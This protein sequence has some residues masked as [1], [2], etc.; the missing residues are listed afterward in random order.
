MVA[1]FERLPGV[2]ADLATAQAT[3]QEMTAAATAQTDAMTALQGEL[4]EANAARTNAEARVAELEIA[5]EAVTTELAALREFKAAADAA[6]AEAE[7]TARREARLNELNEA[8]RTVLASRSEDVQ[9]S[10][11]SRWVDMSDDEWG[12]IRDS[13]NVAKVEPKGQYEA[14][15]EKE[16]QLAAGAVDSAA[17]KYE[18]DRFFK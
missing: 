3:I 9:E 5:A 18:I 15:T 10:L 1:A 6:V 14:A 8:A 16:G 17:G 7:R 4:A 12:V 13:M 11:V 2:E